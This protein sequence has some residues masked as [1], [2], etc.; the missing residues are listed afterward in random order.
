[1]RLHCRPAGAGPKG[2]SKVL[3]GGFTLPDF[4]NINT[5]GGCLVSTVGIGLYFSSAI[6]GVVDRSGNRAILIINGDG[7]Y[8]GASA[9]ISAAVLVSNGSDVTDQAGAFTDAAGSVGYGIAGGGASTSSGVNAEGTGI[10][11]TLFLLGV[12]AGTPSISFG[13]SETIVV[14]DPQLIQLYRELFRDSDP[15]GTGSAVLSRATP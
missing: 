7:V 13:G 2:K 15:F 5:A 10:N 1:M 6:C 4:T 12:G 8:V 14:T 9:S 3:S 11:T